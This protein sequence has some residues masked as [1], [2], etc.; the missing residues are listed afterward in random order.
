MGDIIGVV[1]LALALMMAVAQWSFEPHDLKFLFDPPNRPSH[2]LIGPVG[3]YMAYGVFFLFGV[4][5]FIVPLLLFLFG[6]GFLLQF[7]AYLQRR[8]AWALIL[9]ICTMC[10]VELNAPFVAVQNRHRPKSRECLQT[11]L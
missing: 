1:L 11:G 6:L 4:A 10:L 8:W 9:L 2:N 7:L 3:A 5:G